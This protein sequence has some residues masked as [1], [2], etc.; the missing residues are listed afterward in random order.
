MTV[1]RYARTVLTATV[2]GIRRLRQLH[3]R[4]RGGRRV[5]LEPELGQPV[6]ALMARVLPSRER[7]ELA[8]ELRDQPLPPRHLRDA[9]VP[10]AVVFSIGWSVYRASCCGGAIDSYKFICVTLVLVTADPVQHASQ[11]SSAIQVRVTFPP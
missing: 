11:A 8:P 2:A 4:Q 1:H 9:R 5:H 3:A 6:L 10:L 7:S